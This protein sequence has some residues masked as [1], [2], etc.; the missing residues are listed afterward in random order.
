MR[1]L[2]WPD[3]PDLLGLV[4]SLPELNR[5]ELAEDIAKDIVESAE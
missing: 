2:V 5:A 1:Y 3:S 4:V